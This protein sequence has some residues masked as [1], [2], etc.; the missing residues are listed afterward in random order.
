M[1]RRSCGSWEGGIHE[2]L[3]D[4]VGATGEDSNPRPEAY[5]ATA[6]PLS[7]GCKHQKTLNNQRVVVRSVRIM[8]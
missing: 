7:Y 4:L 2:F 3:L 1:A 5:K 6:L 8:W